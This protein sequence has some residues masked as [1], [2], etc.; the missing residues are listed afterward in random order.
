MQVQTISK[1]GRVQFFRNVQ[2]AHKYALYDDE[3]VWKIS[4]SETI[5]GKLIDYRFRKKRK[6]DIWIPASEDKLKQMN[7]TYRNCQD[8]S[9][10]FW[11][12]QKIADFG[13]I[14]QRPNFASEDD[15][16][17]HYLPQLLVE[18]ISDAE[19]RVKYAVNN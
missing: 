7:P 10:L 18:I 6:S 1:N 5:G 15:W 11:V 9:A 17:A 4:W 19:F 8:K 3:T 13:A 12:N 16:D 14:E 2:S